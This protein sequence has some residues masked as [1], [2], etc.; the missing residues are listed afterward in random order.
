MS[1]K[2]R[3]PLVSIIIVSYDGRELTERCIK[4]VLK[5]TI[6]PNYEI[7]VVEYGPLAPAPDGLRIDDPRVK[8]I[9]IPGNVGYSEANNIGLK[10]ARG[11][12]IAF[13]N[14]DTAVARGWLK[15]L[16]D[17]LLSSGPEVA[18]VQSKLRLMYHPDRIDAIGLSFSPL[19]FL[20]SVGYMEI[21]KGQFDRPH[22]ICII[23]PAACLIRRDALQEIGGLFDPD[24]FWGHE[25]TDLSLRMHLR[26]FKML[27][28]P[29]SLVYHVRSA[30]ISRARSEALTYY[31][32][33]NVV[34]T[35]LK[36]YGLR[37]LAI[38][39]TAHLM[40][41]GLMVIW[42]LASGRGLH[43]IAILKAVWWNLKNL[44]RTMAKR[45]LVQTRIRR[46]PDSVLLAKLSG[47]GIWEILRARHEGPLTTSH[48]RK[49]E[50]SL[51]VNG[52]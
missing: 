27:F 43:A 47:P 13:L 1:E 7:I 17:L 12:L 31:F 2:R 8:V 14:N 36:N 5:N 25:D 16:V 37:S 21:D 46:V 3:N 44:K 20:K 18:A 48:L 26:G 6:Y 32:R 52:D 39:L 38:Y 22:E 33:R 41:L 15:A 11:E 49:R 4:S 51:G 30:T 40:A 35:M 45:A 10:H 50:T 24:Y 34:L 19:G 28:C 23:Q 9:K 42:F 29:S